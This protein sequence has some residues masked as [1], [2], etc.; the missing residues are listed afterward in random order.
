MAT[1]A[2]LPEKVYKRVTA[3][4]EKAQKKEKNF[5][6]L[7]MRNWGKLSPA[8]ILC[9]VEK[10]EDPNL[11][12]NHVV[13]FIYIHFCK[14]LLVSLQEERHVSFTLFVHVAYTPIGGNSVR[15]NICLF[16]CFPL[17]VCFVKHSQ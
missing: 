8:Q 4:I 1:V 7:S 12:Y 13:S 14:L 11:R 2:D 6:L 16:F 9:E 15:L 5:G 10:I 17:L 3:W